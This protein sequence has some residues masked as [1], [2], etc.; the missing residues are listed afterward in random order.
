M[1]L[2]LALSGVPSA[3]LQS[4]VAACIAAL[5]KPSWVFQCQY[6]GQRYQRPNTL[7]LL[8]QRHIRI[9]LLGEFLDLSIVLTDRRV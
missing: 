9:A 2:R 6:V 3:R 5:W 8:E 1:Q 4:H 7:H